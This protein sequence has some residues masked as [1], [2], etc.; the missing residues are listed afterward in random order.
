MVIDESKSLNEQVPATDYNI[1]AATTND[2]TTNG[3]PQ[4]LTF[5]G[6]THEGLVVISLTTTQRDALTGVGTGAIIWNS[7]DSELQHYTGSA[8]EALGGAGGGFLEV[9]TTASGSIPTGTLPLAY[10]FREAGTINELRIIALGVSGTVSEFLK[11]QVTK[12]GTA[13]TD[14]IFTSDTE[15][16][17]EGNA[18][19]SND[20]YTSTGTLDTG[21]GHDVVSAGDVL[22]FIVTE[23]SMSPGATDLEVQM[24]FT[25]S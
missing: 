19:A 5:A 11:V 15:A 4:K 21:A 17:I 2:I 8:W 18:T 23:N 14:S 9:L 12:N 22:W 13:T 25:P 10:R 7:T 6:T 16:S 24:K 1:I 20:I 3:L